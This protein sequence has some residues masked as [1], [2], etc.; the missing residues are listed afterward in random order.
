V[1]GRGNEQRGL[2]K[3]DEKERRKKNVSLGAAAP[4]GKAE[5]KKSGA[6]KG[7]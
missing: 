4:R 7:R 3:K 2:E 1:L 6:K 5:K